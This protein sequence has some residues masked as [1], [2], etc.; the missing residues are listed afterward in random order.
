MVA[1]AWARR[2]RSV[3]EELGVGVVG[4]GCAGV[5]HMR[6]AQRATGARLVGVAESSAQRRAEVSK[7]FDC[8]TLADYHALLQRADVQIIT[9]ALPHWLHEQAAIDVANAGKHVLIEKP[10]A[11]VHQR[12]RGSDRRD[13]ARRASPG[14]W[15]L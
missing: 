4:Y 12:V 11:G 8:L 15:R 14:R 10:L 6:A 9:I 5:G 3:T 1:E 13:Q 2:A 7:N